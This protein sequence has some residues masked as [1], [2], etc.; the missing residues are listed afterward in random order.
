M[1]THN[2]F[3]K[4]LLSNKLLFLIAF[5]CFSTFNASAQAVVAV[6]VNWPV[7][8]QQNLVQIRTAGNATVYQDCVPGNCFNNN[9][10]GFVYNN[11]G[12]TTLAFGNYN[13]LVADAA[14]NGWDGA[15][16]VRVLVNGV[17]V[18]N[19]TLAAGFFQFIPFTVADTGV[20]INPPLTIFDEFD[21]E[22]D[23]AVTGGSL[24]DS[25]TNTC[26]IVTTSSEILTSS[27]PPT[28]TIERAYLFWAQSNYERDDQVTFE[29]QNVSA[30]VVNVFRFGGLGITFFGMVS[31]VTSIIQ[32]ISDPSANTY[33][34]TDLTVDNTGTYCTGNV[35]VGAWS[36]MIFYSDAS[37]PAASINLYNG[38][39]GAQNTASPL[40]F[41]LDNFFANS[42]SDAK[43][44]V[45]SWEGDAPNTG[46]EELSLSTSASPTPFPLVG[47][48]DNDGVTLDNPFNSTVYD[49][50]TGVDRTRFGIDLDTYDI[51]PFINV[52]E[53]SVTTN[54]G[55]GGDFILLNSVVLKVSSN[56]MTGNVFEDI[57]YGGGN[58]RD[59]T[60][61]SGAPIE[62]ATVELYD[63]TGTLEDA[64]VTD[65]SGEYVFGGMNNGDFSVRVVNSTVRSTRGGGSGCTT[66]LPIQT[67]KRNFSL[68]TH[69]DITT[70]I[71]G[72]D[73]SG[74]DTAAGVLTGA[75]T[76][77]SVSINNQGVVDLDFGFNFNTIVNS[78]QE[79]Q[80]SLRQFI[81]NSNALDETGLDIVPHPDDASFDP[82]SGADTSIFMIPPAND[83]LGRTA[84]TR[85]TSGYFDIVIPNG[86][87]LPNISDANTVID[88]RSQTVYSS[89]SGDD[90]TGT[91]GSG[92][93]NVGTSASTLPNY[94]LPEIQ[95]HQN[96]GDV[97]IVD[98]DN[99]TIQNLSVYSNN[100]SGIR[101]DSGTN[102]IISSN[103]IGVNAAGTAVQNIRVGVEMIGGT[104]TIENNFIS[105]NRTAGVLINGGTS[106][107]VRNNHIT[108]NGGGL[109][110][111]FC[112]DNLRLQSGT[113][114]EIR[115][116]LIESAASIGID[117]NGSAGNI[118]ITENTI[119]T[120]GTG[121]TCTENQGILLSGSNSS[122]SNNI[123][124]NNG[125]AGIALSSGNTSGNLISQNSIF[126]NGTVSDALGIDLNNDGVTLNDLGDADT[127]PNGRQN[128]PVF[129]SATISGNVLKVVGWATPGATLEFFLTD[130]N[131]GTASVGD[132]QIGLTQDYG[133]GQVFIASAIEGSPDDNDSTSSSYTDADGNTDNTERF[134][135]SITLGS[136]IPVGSII[137]ATATTSNSTSE[138]GNTFPIGAAT[139]IT[140]RR[141]TYRVNN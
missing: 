115:N 128:F 5:L 19:T 102:T 109:S 8:A 138:F 1:K 123:I 86:N 61:A 130:I 125:G 97:L 35:T 42:N 91:V 110:G 84:D 119:T 65:S 44:T 15:A 31:D 54:V 50:T 141:I 71:G 63:N 32:G 126:A 92:G 52:G 29:G 66:C 53:T 64:T 116:N 59:I 111:T 2:H 11:T 75:Q 67:F 62:N 87:D 40:P 77:S 99:T 73:P 72:T 88:G 28:A 98:A 7:Q 80:G 46:G 47:D 60:T 83:R 131:Q 78:N 124:N 81:I 79:G 103:L 127:G 139:V 6:E 17:E 41:L 13:L 39:A 140:N 90:N 37:L 9:N 94:N 113:G 117:A 26:S 118:T 18:L 20:S 45:L 12:S 93:T 36:L 74:Q 133:E 120:S 122:M 48:G 129:E 49:G 82:A 24:R 55:V 16:T 106:T 85:F 105:G 76:V 68:G 114:I 22:F 10:T 132:N 30:D 23:Y 104:A 108:N 43:T 95:V 58:G 33:D 121:P 112:N 134:N 137:T 69:T 135:F 14:S 101:I 57:N 100:N 4:A 96:N 107:I 70:Q 89:S 21:G 38:F 136:T 51:S 34:F 25:D 56:L 3:I 27:I